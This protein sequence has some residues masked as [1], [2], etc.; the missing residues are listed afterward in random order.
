MASPY[1]MLNMAVAQLSERHKRARCSR[2]A[3]TGNQLESGNLTGTQT[4]IVGPGKI[5]QHLRECFDR[6]SDGLKFNLAAMS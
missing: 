3:D 6:S 5:V 2:V 4:I 1:C